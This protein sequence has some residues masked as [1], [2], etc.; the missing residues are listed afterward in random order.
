[1]V[2]SLKKISVRYVQIPA[3]KAKVVRETVLELQAESIVQ[4]WRQGDGV[5]GDRHKAYK[6][7]ESGDNRRN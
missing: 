2:T 1:M 5:T 6:S 3:A 4:V 7:Q